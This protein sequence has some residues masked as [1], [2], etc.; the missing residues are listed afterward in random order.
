MSE[1]ANKFIEKHSDFKVGI[2]VSKSVDKN[3][4]VNYLKEHKFKFELFDDSYQLMKIA[5][6]GIVKTGT[7]NLEAALSGMPFVMLYQTSAVSYFLGKRLVN[8]PYISLVNILSNDFVVKEF[9]Q[10]FKV[11]E[12]ANELSDIITNRDKYDSLQDSFRKIKRNLG[13]VGASDNSAKAIIEYLKINLA[14]S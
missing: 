2:A 14:T 13:S 11:N 7:S 4:I 3:Y 10:T 8:M 1:I 9:I 5:K 6:V 12:V